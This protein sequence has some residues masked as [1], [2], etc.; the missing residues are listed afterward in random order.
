[1]GKILSQEEID[2]LL[3]SQ[4][5]IGSDEPGGESSLAG[6]ITYNFRRPDRVSKDQIRSLHFLHDRFARNV[7]TSM[8]AFLR[9]VSD[10]TIVSV[11]QFA[12]SEFLMSLP[13]PTAFYAIGIEPFELVGAMELNPSIAFTMIDRMLGGTGTSG[14]MNRALTEIEQ[15]VIDSVVK[16]LLENL[17]E[18]WRSINEDVEFSISGRETRP[19]MLSVAAPNEVVILLVFDVRVGD[20]RGMLNL[21]IPASIIEAAGSS[22]AQGWHRTRKEPTRADR[23]RLRENLGRV[24]MPVVAD[25]ESALQARELLELRPGDILSLGHSLRHP[26]EVKVGGV[27]KFTARLTRIDN[28]AGVSIEAPVYPRRQPLALVAPMPVPVEGAA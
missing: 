15:N 21:C 14:A 25:I 18:A 17:T 2:A 28:H 10:M 13:D 22:F 3:V 23:R 27:S 12:Y 6:A 5:D 24:P 11:E 4:S 1:M 16:L 7:A 20:T 26:V 19:Q 9:T 8:S